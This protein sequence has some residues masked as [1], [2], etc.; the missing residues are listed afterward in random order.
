MEAAIRAEL[1]AEEVLWASA[2]GRLLYARRE[3]GR[4]ARNLFILSIITFWLGMF[5]H[6][7]GSPNQWMFICFGLLILLVAFC[8]L[9]TALVPVLLPGRLFYVITTQRAIIFEKT[10]N[11]RIHSFDATTLRGFERVSHGGRSG[12]IIFKSIVERSGRAASSLECGFLGLAS[13]VEPEALL[14]RIV[15]HQAEA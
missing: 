7:S 6:K 9:I 13:F 2:P 5:L 15:Q 1:G 4:V 11:Q 12:D 10:W 3:S 14:K 8:Q